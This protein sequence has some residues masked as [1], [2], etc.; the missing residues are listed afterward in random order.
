MSIDLHRAY[1]QKFRRFIYFNSEISN[2]MEL[3]SS[4]RVAWYPAQVA[5]ARRSALAD[6]E[7]RVNWEIKQTP[8]SRIFYFEHNATV[9]QFIA[10]LGIRD[11]SS[12][13][14]YEGIG[15]RLADRAV[16]AYVSNF[17]SP[18]LIGLA[19]VTP[20]QKR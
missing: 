20:I 13:D 18:D 19:K 2:G 6:M 1:D 15:K 3:Y 14:D 12:P 7:L 17:G 10:D 9:Q 16:I 4:N 8:F 11:L 5:S